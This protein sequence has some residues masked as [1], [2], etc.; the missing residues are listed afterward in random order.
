MIKSTKA[1]T[2][3]RN[4]IQLEMQITTKEMNQLFQD[5]W[6]TPAR[7]NKGQ[8]VEKD[9]LITINLFQVLIKLDM[10]RDTVENVDSSSTPY[11]K[12]G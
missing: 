1:D 8:Q 12:D 2:K 10:S 4:E 9:R 5:G 7:R 3:K 11:Y 6:V